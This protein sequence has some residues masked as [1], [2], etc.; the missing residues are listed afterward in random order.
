MVDP[1]ITPTVIT[2]ITHIVTSEPF[3]EFGLAFIKGIGRKSG[4]SAYKLGSSLIGVPDASKINKSSQNSPYQSAV[5]KYLEAKQEYLDKDINLRER[6][7]AAKREFSQNLLQLLGESQKQNNE[8][9]LREIQ[10]NWDKDNWFSKLD[11]HETE[12]ILRQA[13]HRLLILASPPDI[14]SDCPETFENNL[15]KEIKNRLGLFIGQYY[16]VNS[17]IH[18]VQF[19]GDY[20]KEPISSIDVKRLQFL[21]EGL[22]TI[23]LYSDITDYEVHFHLDCLGGGKTHQY[24]LPAWNW[25]ESYKALKQ[26]GKTEKEA[27][28]EIRKMIVDVYLL[29]SAFISDWYYLQI[30]LLYEPQLTKASVKLPDEWVT[31]CQEQ[32][33]HLYRL[34]QAELSYQEGL[35]LL[36]KKEYEKSFQCFQATLAVKPDNQVAMFY[37]EYAKGFYLLE[38][39]EY[40]E[41]LP[42]FDAVLQQQPELAE[43]WFNK[44]VALEQLNQI[45]KAKNALNQALTLQ[46][47]L[48]ERL[49]P[50]FAYLCNFTETLPN[51][52][53]LEMIAI[54]A[55]EFMMGPPGGEG[56][57]D[58][59]PQHKVRLKGF[60]L[61]KYPITQAQYQAVMG[62]NPSMIEGENNPVE[63]V[64]WYDAQ[65]FCR[66]LSQIT[67]NPYQLPSEAQ[68]E[69]ACRAGNSGKW[70]FG[71]NEN[72]IKEYAWYRENPG[73]I[74][75]YDPNEETHPV[76]EKKPNQ[77][78][79]YDMHGN[80]WEWCEDNYE[81][82]NYQ[83]TSTDGSPC[84]NPNMKFG[85]SRGGSW[86]YDLDWCSSF[87][88]SL[89]N[90]RDGAID[91]GFRVV[92]SSPRT[93]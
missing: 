53:K 77:W 79:L 50:E 46:P 47:N 3:K 72:L 90:P 67:G 85:V 24:P 56:D 55:G 31:P 30:N 89:C 68:W 4:E 54:P 17:P 18:P 22:S 37:A 74:W 41:V 59:H 82:N 32:L 75:D 44:G 29:L 10:N 35:W 6:E 2:V 70:C 91:T 76:G 92:R 21:L 38:I 88:R 71:D 81:E 7:L 80:V 13:E 11:R 48:F 66:K 36:E 60:Y 23:I 51:G 26:E 34:N 61:G 63:R 1:I 45:E 9:K 84:Q 20:F 19:Y 62:N 12:Q 58:E 42:C 14:S 43:V 5:K 25:E 27:L 49:T 8:T 15:N 52:I 69:Y 39:G 73:S 16:S 83:N 33:D 93:F 64:N 78:G 65:A 87:S 86:V 28:R 57:S 40:T